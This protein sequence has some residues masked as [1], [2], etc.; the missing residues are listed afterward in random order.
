VTFRHLAQSDLRLMLLREC[1]H[2]AFR[3]RRKQR[4]RLAAECF[5]WLTTVFRVLPINSWKRVGSPRAG[6]DLSSQALRSIPSYIQP[7]YR[8]LT[9]EFGQFRR[10]LDVRKLHSAYGNYS[11]AGA[12]A[13][14]S[15]RAWITRGHG[16][17]AV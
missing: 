1:L 3:R 9:P 17:T 16:E 8:R 6:Q 14:S 5:Y 11:G 10:D 12:T 4:K 7:W 15:A 13:S 2:L